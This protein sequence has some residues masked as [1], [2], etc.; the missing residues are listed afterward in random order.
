MDEWAEFHGIPYHHL[1]VTHGKRDQQENE[2]MNIIE[3]TGTELVVLARYMQILPD[4]FCAKLRGRIINI[5]HSFLPSFK[6]AR[7]YH[8]AHSRLHAR[9]HHRIRK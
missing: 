2:L 9:L 4:E 1:P 3:K 5:H 7:P 8:R 6:G